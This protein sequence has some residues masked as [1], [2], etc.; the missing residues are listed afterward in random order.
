MTFKF[1][2]NRRLSNMGFHRQKGSWHHLLEY[3]FLALLKNCLV[4]GL[5]PSEPEAAHSVNF[6][7]PPIKNWLPSNL[8][9][10][11]WLIFQE[12]KIGFN[13]STGELLGPSRT[14]FLM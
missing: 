2:E 14:V 13:F 11:I 12:N 6:I 4:S 10:L 9:M 7:P 3:L 1:Q 5:F 8:L